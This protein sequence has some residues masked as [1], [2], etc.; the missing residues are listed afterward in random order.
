MADK[1]PGPCEDPVEKQG[2]CWKYNPKRS[3]FEPCSLRAA[4]RDG[5]M[6]ALRDKWPLRGGGRA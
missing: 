1:L 6:A 2:G 4:H 5:G 3:C